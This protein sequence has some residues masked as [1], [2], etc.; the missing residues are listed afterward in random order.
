MAELSDEL[1]EMLI[2][3]SVGVLKKRLSDIPDDHILTLEK[4]KASSFHILK[5]VEPENP[6]FY[7]R[8]SIDVFSTWL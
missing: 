6:N 5:A 1:K 3:N 8:G 4:Q 2:L 7:V